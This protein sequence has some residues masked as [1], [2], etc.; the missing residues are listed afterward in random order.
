[1]DIDPVIYAGPILDGER[2][3]LVEVTSGVGMEQI[4]DFHRGIVS[5]M[6]HNYVFNVNSSSFK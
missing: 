3:R 2:M 4:Y 5:L 1:M 6:Q